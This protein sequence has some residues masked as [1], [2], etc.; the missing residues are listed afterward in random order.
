MKIPAMLM[1]LALLCAADGPALAATKVELVVSPAPADSRGTNVK[2]TYVLTAKAPGKTK[3]AGQYIIAFYA[4]GIFLQSFRQKTLP[5]SIT[6]NFAGM[7]PGSHEVKVDV[8]A[9]AQIVASAKAA[10]TVEQ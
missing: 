5:V 8:E 4:D 3:D 1:A 9:N 7:G 6:R 10:I 2:N